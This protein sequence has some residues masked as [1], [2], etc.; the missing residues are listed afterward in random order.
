MLVNPNV[1][2]NIFNSNTSNLPS[3]L[4]LIAAVSN[5]HTDWQYL[6]LQTCYLVIEPLYGEY[7]LKHVQIL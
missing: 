4:F 5:L 1:N 3:C 2:A 7:S 6:K